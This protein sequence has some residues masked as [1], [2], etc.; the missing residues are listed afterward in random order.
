M[1][2]GLIAGS[3]RSDKAIYAARENI[4]K[5]PHGEQIHLK[6]IDFREIEDLSHRII[7]TNPPYG[8]RLE[9]GKDLAGFYK[10]MGDFL[11]RRCKG[12]TAYVYFGN[13]SLIPYIGLK[14]T[15]KRPLP[16]GGLDGRLVKFEI[17]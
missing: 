9:K 15:W 12:S 3:D 5:L 1:P 11:K 2:K 7:V 13:R 8:I 10:E 14:P 16:S 6:V 4:Q 17:Y